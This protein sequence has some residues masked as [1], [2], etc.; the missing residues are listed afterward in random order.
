MVTVRVLL[1]L[2][3]STNT[4]RQR[5]KHRKA[6]SVIKGMNI[7]TSVL[8]GMYETCRKMHKKTQDRSQKSI[9]V[10]TVAGCRGTTGKFYNP[11]TPEEPMGKTT[12]DLRFCNL[13]RCEKGRPEVDTENRGD[14]IRNPHPH[15]HT[16]AEQDTNHHSLPDAT[17][18]KFECVLH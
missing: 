4:C 14:F 13:C 17:V 11:R 12:Q 2:T 5:Q 7:R 15:T 3:R 18:M 6:R 1:G 8:L 16:E 9:I 10:L